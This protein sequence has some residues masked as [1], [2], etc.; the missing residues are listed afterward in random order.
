MVSV[1]FKSFDSY[2]PAYKQ[3]LQANGPILSSDILVYGADTQFGNFTP[4]SYI[5]VPIYRK[6]V[7]EEERRVDDIVGTVMSLLP[8]ENYF[9]DLLPEGIDGITLVVSNTCNQTFT[10]EINGPEVAYL[11]IGDMHDSS[12]DEYVIETTFSP[13][14]A[15][16]PCAVT[17]SLY[18]TLEFESTYATNK[19]LVYTIAVLGVFLLTAAVFFLYDCF[20][21]RRQ[22]KVLL[23]AEKSTAIVSSLFPQQVAD[24]L[25]EQEEEKKKKAQAAKAKK[26]SA[27]GSIRAR[28]GGGDAV[29]L[30]QVMG[31]VTKGGSMMAAGQ[32]QNDHVDHIGTLNDEDNGVS[33]PIAELFP[34]ATVLFADIGTFVRSM[35]T[36]NFLQI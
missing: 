7:L 15:E 29:M 21:E 26:N 34:S 28:G 23:T 31:G 12:F 9:K 16:M 2:P 17:L 20:V 10:Y 5:L 1:L 6:V 11:G 3:L 30:G 27:L 22:S 8:W 14:E 25:M 13:F 24:K 18:P 32:I 35:H 19:P 4:E 33:K 36:S